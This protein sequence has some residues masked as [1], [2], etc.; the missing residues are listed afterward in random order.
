MLGE[1]GAIAE[2]LVMTCGEGRLAVKRGEPG[3]ADYLY[4]CHFSDGTL[5]PLKAPSLR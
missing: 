5:Q 4:W 1:S 3:F 2:Y